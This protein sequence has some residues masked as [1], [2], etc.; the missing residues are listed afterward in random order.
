MLVIE[1]EMLA[2]LG[3]DS[4]DYQEVALRIYGDTMVLRRADARPLNMQEVGQLFG[5]SPWDAV[6]LPENLDLGDTA[7]ALREVLEL[8]QGGPLT[9]GE[10]AELLNLKPGATSARLKRAILHNHIVKEGIY[11][12]LN[13]EM[14]S[15]P[16]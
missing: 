4:D 9:S 3:L 6:S 8:L 14:F 2:Q 11:Y 15:S 5:L 1:R 7:P 10:I 12:R 16:S 13:P